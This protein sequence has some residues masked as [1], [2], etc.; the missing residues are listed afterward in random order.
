[1]IASKS[2]HKRLVKQQTAA[3][4]DLAKAELGDEM[5]AQQWMLA[6]NPGLGM[7]RPIEMILQGRGD[8]LLAWMR[9]Q[10]RR[11]K[12]PNAEAQVRSR[13]AAE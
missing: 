10:A 12:P 8:R 6:K 5:K 4:L 11:N 7:V 13:S 9:E 2:Q 3:A 1:M